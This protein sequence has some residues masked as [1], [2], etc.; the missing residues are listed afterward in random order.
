MGK[1]IYS[2]GNTIEYGI[3]T[4]YVDTEEDK[5]NLQK[6]NLKTK[7]Y[8]IAT[9]KWYIVNGSGEWVPFV[10]EGSG[11]TDA[12]LY[13]EQELTNAQQA[14]ARQNINAISLEDVGTVFHLKGSL[15]TYAD[16]LLIEDQEIGD[17]YFITSTQKEYV[18]IT[19]PTFPNGYWEEYGADDV[20]VVTVNNTVTPITAD[21]TYAEVQAAITAG[22]TVVYIG[23]GWQATTIQPTS[24]AVYAYGIVL[25]ANGPVLVILFHTSSS[26]TIT[27]VPLQEAPTTTAVTGSTPT[28]AI[29]EN[30]HIYECGEV[31]SL[32]VTDIDNPGSFIL[33]FI[34]GAT[35]TTTTLPAGMV[36]P[37][38]FTPEINTRYEI[39]CVDGYA[40]AAG[41]PYTPPAVEE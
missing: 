33:R 15:P 32:T 12:V 3:K 39:N 18:W 2:Q 7:C 28:I 24:N 14:Q 22:K 23:T 11:S 8:V 36:F 21:K 9:Q 29:C 37:E 6:V 17:V 16:L 4:Y 40:L 5:N 30:N 10:P 1:I 35:A 27:Q 19:N 13:T 34:S 20:F 25:A 26:L 38:A 41:W 31:T